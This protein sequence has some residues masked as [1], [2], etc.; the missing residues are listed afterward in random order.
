[1]L[2]H[3]ITPR[4]LATIP[5]ALLLIA[6]FAVGGCRPVCP[7][8]PLASERTVE[9]GVVLRRQFSE[10][11]DRPRPYRHIHTLLPG[12]ELIG[13]N[14]GYEPTGRL[15]DKLT[16]T[17]KGAV[18]QLDWI[19]VHRRHYVDA[20]HAKGFSWEGREDLKMVSVWARWRVTP[21][22]AEALR[23]AWLRLAENPPDFRLLGRNCV[24]RCNEMLVEAGILEGG[25]PGV[26]TP[27]QMLSKI[28]ACLGDRVTVEQGFFGLD[29]EGRPYLDPLPPVE[30][31]GRYPRLQP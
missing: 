19:R 17:E 28:R 18:R 30:G 25:L 2:A 4:R 9:I 20:D 26:H 11:I 12:G 5:C 23:A 3:A 24:T 13:Y 29:A 10:V 14:K 6:G 16:R 22:Q 1:M 15:V 31:V 7:P 21:A 27:N 8:V